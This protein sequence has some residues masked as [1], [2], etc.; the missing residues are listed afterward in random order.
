MKA[1]SE[2]NKSIHWH[3]WGFKGS[4]PGSSHC[5][6]YKFTL[7]YI[8]FAIS[9]SQVLEW[10]NNSVEKIF[11]HELYLPQYQNIGVLSVTNF[12]LHPLHF[13]YLQDYSECHILAYQ[14]KSN[15]RK[16]YFSTN[17]VGD[18]TFFW[19]IFS[20]TCILI[21]LSKNMFVK[22]ILTKATNAL[23]IIKAIIIT[24]L[25]FTTVSGLWHLIALCC[26][27]SGIFCFTC[28]NA[29]HLAAENFVFILHMLKT[30]SEDQVDH[31]K[32]S[33]KD[34][35]K[36][37]RAS[38]SKS[39]NFFHSQ[40]FKGSWPCNSQEKYFISSILK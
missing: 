5:M 29:F 23:S 37:T 33:T 4:W 22:L 18:M 30:D 15:E 7:N 3:Y 20:P 11:Y 26:A 19:L 12:N 1:I 16:K 10:A 36:K 17:E 31:R 35:T 28:W 32:H 25:Q 40:G 27:A 8:N 13:L 39:S 24:I 21:F 2:D 38:D 9:H 34:R 6:L 14:E